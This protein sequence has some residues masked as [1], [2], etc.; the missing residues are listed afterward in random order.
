M[1][2]AIPITFGLLIAIAA[3][4][5]NDSTRPATPPAAPRGVYS[6]TGDHSVT[7]HWLLNTE[8]NVTAYRIYE[9]GC[10]DGS[11]CPYSQVGAVGAGADHFTVDGLQNGV[12]RF[13]AVSAVNS[14]NKESDLSYDTIYD[15]PRPAG[16]NASIFNFRGNPR[17]YADSAWDFSGMTSVSFFD[18][19]ADVFYDDTTNVALMYAADVAT[20][21]QDAGYSTTLDHVDFAPSTGWSPTGSVEL[22][23]GHCY[24]V[25]TRTN[26]YAKFRVTAIDHVAHTLTFDWA[27]QTDPNNGELR[28]RRAG[29]TGMSALRANMIER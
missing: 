27:Y 13:F 9:A 10:A 22:I 2:H 14:Q 23:V 28:N 17:H 15:T 18:P 1:R 20:D 16:T 12:T 8:A 21:I 24:V 19:A 7:L 29:N 4:G 6:V 11:T 26:N 5:C 3:A 25:A